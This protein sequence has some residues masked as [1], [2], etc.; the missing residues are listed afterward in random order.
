MKLVCGI[1]L[2]TVVVLLARGGETYESWAGLESC[3]IGGFILILIHLI[4]GY[5]LSKSVAVKKT[6]EET[7]M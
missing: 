6:Q 4:L 7:K 2:Y 3:G 1:F 5:F